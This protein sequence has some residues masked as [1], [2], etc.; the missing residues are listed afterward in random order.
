MRLNEDCDRESHF[1]ADGVASIVFIDSRMSADGQ[2]SN[3][4]RPIAISNIR[5]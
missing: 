5:R 2:H 1:E 4:L 3:F